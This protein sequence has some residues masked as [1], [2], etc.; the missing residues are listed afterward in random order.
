VKK[1]SS[2]PAKGMPYLDYDR[3]FDGNNWELE[4][5]DMGGRTAKMV[6]AAIRNAAYRERISVTVRRGEGGTLCVHADRSRQPSVKGT[7][8]T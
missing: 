4:K 6:S 7:K 8:R 3:L 5:A 2:M 1:I